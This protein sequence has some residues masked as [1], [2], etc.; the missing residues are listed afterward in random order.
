MINFFPRFLELSK[1]LDPGRPVK[2][3]KYAILDD[4]IR[5]LNQLKAEAKEVKEAN[6]KLEEEIKSLK[7]SESYLQNF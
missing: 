1:L 7:V 3:D 4:A 2:P 6:T 5:L